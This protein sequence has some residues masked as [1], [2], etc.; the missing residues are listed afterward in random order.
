MRTDQ[1]GRVRHIRKKNSLPH[2]FNQKNGAAGPPLKPVLSYRISAKELAEAVERKRGSSKTQ[3]ELLDDELFRDLTLTDSSVRSLLADS[4]PESSDTRFSQDS[5]IFDFEETG[6]TWR[7]PEEERK[8]KML[9]QRKQQWRAA[10]TAVKCEESE[11]L[12]T[13][14]NQQPRDN[15]ALLPTDDLHSK[16]H[17]HLLGGSEKVSRCNSQRC[18]SLSQTPPPAVKVGS[19]T[20]VSSPR[21]ASV[22]IPSP[23][24]SCCSSLAGSSSLTDSNSSAEPAIHVASPIEMPWQWRIQ[25]PASPIHSPI[26]ISPATWTLKKF[27]R[28]VGP[29]RNPDCSCAHCLDHFA[30]L[31]SIKESGGMMRL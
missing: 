14:P 18:P 1:S 10:K 19:N 6:R 25:Q 5:S 15:A 24:P 31:R 22:R 20:S 8:R 16:L 27:G 13:L 23:S 26:T 7:S 3:D 4:E 17:R 21:P 28:H 30:R 11:R 2:S 9:E 29:A 12:R